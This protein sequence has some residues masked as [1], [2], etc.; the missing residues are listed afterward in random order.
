[1]IASALAADPAFRDVL[2]HQRWVAGARVAVAAATAAAGDDRL[3]GLQHN[4][5]AGRDRIEPAVTG[6]L[7]LRGAAAGMAAANAKRRVDGAV[8]GEP[9]LE[10]GVDR[11]V[12]A[13]AARR[14]AEAA[15]PFA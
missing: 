13:K 1:H 5:A 12:F 3:A 15:G 6:A 14:A 10:R 8:A 11:A 7:E 2:S 4:A 9:R